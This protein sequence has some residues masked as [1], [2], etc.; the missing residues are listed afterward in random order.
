MNIL[1]V[2]DEVS[3]RKS[4]AYII[5]N[6]FEG[7][8]HIFTSNSAERALKSAHKNRIDLLI[9][10]ICLGDMNGIELSKE[11]LGIYPECK[12]IYVSAYD[13]KEYLK[14][15]IHMKVLGYIEKPIDKNQILGIIEE[16]LIDEESKASKIDL[17]TNI[18]KTEHLIDLLLKDD[19]NVEAEA[20]YKSSHLY[21]CSYY[22]VVSFESEVLSD[23]ST[24]SKLMSI[25]ATKLHDMRIKFEF[26]TRKEFIVVTGGTEYKLI[27]LLIICILNVLEQLDLKDKMIVGIGI[28]KNDWHEISASYKSAI[29]GLNKGFYEG[30]GV[31]SSVKAEFN[32]EEVN[33]FEITNNFYEL[34]KNQK[35]EALIAY[36]KEIA[37]Q[38]RQKGNINKQ[39]TVQLIEAMIYQINLYSERN[40][41]LLQKSEYTDVNSIFLF[42]EWIAKIES[43]IVNLCK[44][45]RVGDNVV[46]LTKKFIM[47][48]YKTSDLS[49]KDIADYVHL[50]V[51]YLSTHFKKVC[52]IT[53]N[54]YLTEFRIEKAKEYI[55]SGRYNADEIGRLVGYE[56]GNYFY[57]I[58]KKQTGMTT[59]EY[60]KSVGK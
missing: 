50:N 60:R 27:D 21:D 4:L 26:Q 6:G 23:S 18:E 30:Y 44:E 34:L 12:I 45:Q 35:E 17:Y 54:S 58:F 7:R 19:K 57:R 33:V 32:S 59:K 49:I 31:Y 47:E 9:S 13:E 22:S 56:D 55:R 51:S 15:A 25:L 14:A 28:R 8:C 2:D 16:L 52:G 53:I 46:N 24:R 20:L 41:V 29:A 36:I 42:D 39:T 11:I 48:N 3:I 43:L 40:N 10:D 37:R 1:I 38:I 5:N